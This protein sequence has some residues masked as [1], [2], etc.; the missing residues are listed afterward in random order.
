MLTKLISELRDVL[1]ATEFGGDYLSPDVMALLIREYAKPSH[2]LGHLKWVY[3]KLPARLWGQYSPNSRELRVSNIKTK[4][5]FKQQV[6]T[7]LHEIQHWNQHVDDT[8]RA[9]AEPQKYGAV[10][11]DKVHSLLYGLEKAKVGYWNVSYEKDA[12]AF[13]TKHLDDAMRKIGTHYSGKVTGSTLDT[14]IEEIVD[15]YGDIEKVSRFQIGTILKDHD[16]NT[17]ESG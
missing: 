3:M 2:Q 14:A 1:E 15:T 6:E 17:S 10:N 5:L 8:A 16:L 12:R 9:A 11:P 7:I 13:A 4:G